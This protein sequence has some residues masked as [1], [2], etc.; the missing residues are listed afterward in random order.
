[1]LHIDTSALAVK[2]IMTDFSMALTLCGVNRTAYKVETDPANYS[3][4]VI[5]ILKFFYCSQKISFTVDTFCINLDIRAYCSGFQLC[6]FKIYKFIYCLHDLLICV[7]G[8]TPLN[9]MPDID[10]V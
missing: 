1:M 7:A 9:G 3:C 5:T 6:I 8:S 4:C 10:R 2:S